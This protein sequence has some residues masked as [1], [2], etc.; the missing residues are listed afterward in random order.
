[1]PAGGWK[2]SAVACARSADPSF[3][4]CATTIPGRARGGLSCRQRREADEAISPCHPYAV[5]GVAEVGS[6]GGWVQ[7]YQVDLDPNRLR[8]YDLRMSEVVRAVE[9]SNSNV[10]GNVIEAN[11]TW[12]VVRGLGLIESVE[13]L[14]GIRPR[15]VCIQT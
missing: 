14:A 13:D 10:G 12:T 5:P 1:M 3:D 4:D 2:G 15:R 6:V 9:E 8:S 7:Q 11:G